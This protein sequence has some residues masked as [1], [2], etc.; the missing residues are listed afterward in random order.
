MNVGQSV[1]IPAKIT[2]VIDSSCCP[3]WL[4]LR[5]VDA[6]GRE[7]IVEEKAPVVTSED[8]IPGASYIGDAAIAGVI[9]E[10]RSINHGRQVF[11]VD[12]DKPWGIEAKCGTTRFEIPAE[13]LTLDP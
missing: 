9:A 1:H 5:F 6:Y 4:E 13:D 12:T 7:W 2:R 8:V 11:L 10:D 3:D